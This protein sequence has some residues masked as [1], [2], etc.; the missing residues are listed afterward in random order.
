MDDLKCAAG[1][2]IGDDE[3]NKDILEGYNWDSL[4][5]I[6]YVPHFS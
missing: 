1:C 6:G 3:Y 4:S 5:S 2:L